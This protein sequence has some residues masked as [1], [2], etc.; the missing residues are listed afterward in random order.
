MVAN[1]SNY[2]STTISL[3]E[4]LLG[5]FF[6]ENAIFLA[7]RFPFLLFTITFCNPNA[8][9][10][11]KIVTLSALFI[12]HIDIF[13]IFAPGRFNIIKFT[14]MDNPLFQPTQHSMKRLLRIE[15]VGKNNDLFH[16][17]FD[18]SW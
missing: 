2:Q 9:F 18:S 5:A 14:K 6:V 15:S 8:L 11:Y 7:I 13:T 16:V 17:V 1:S 4:S 3:R 10:Y 12:Y